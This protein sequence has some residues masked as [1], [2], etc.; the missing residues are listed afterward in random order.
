MKKH[1]LNRLL[2]RKSW[3]LLVDAGLLTGRSPDLP[4]SV[5]DIMPLA[6]CPEVGS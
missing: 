6:R 4:K 5:P 1:L 3:S 2:A